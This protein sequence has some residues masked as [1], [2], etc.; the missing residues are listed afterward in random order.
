[1]VD[2]SRGGEGG[3][4]SW[5]GLAN[6]GIGS[7]PTGMTQQCPEEGEGERRRR[8]RQRRVGRDG[9]MEMDEVVGTRRG[10]PVLYWHLL[11]LGGIVWLHLGLAY[12]WQPW[13]CQSIFGGDILLLEQGQLRARMLTGAESYLQVGLNTHVIG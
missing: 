8:G 7:L 2:G 12:E 10:R 1:M 6:D 9:W 4:P 11:M 13:L 3:G 5:L